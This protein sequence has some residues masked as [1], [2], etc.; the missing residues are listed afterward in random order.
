MPAVYHVGNGRT[1]TEKYF[2]ERQRH[3]ERRVKLVALILLPISI[4]I[5]PYSLAMC[6]RL[7]LH[8]SV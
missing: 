4:K 2:G 5:Y 6:K 7:K 1:P 8:M 3:V